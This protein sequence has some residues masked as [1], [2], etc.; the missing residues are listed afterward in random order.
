MNP[1]RRGLVL[2]G[3]VAAAANA[4]SAQAPVRA[5][6]VTVR[7]APQTVGIGEAI[8]LEVRVRTAPGV[9]VRFPPVPDSA[10]SIEPL[11]PR[12]ITDRSTAEQLDRTAT[13]RFIAWDLGAR[14]LRLGDVTLLVEGSARRYPV[15]VPP[16][17]VRS[18]L[19]ADS[20]RRT[21]REAKPMAALPWDGWRWVIALVVV[22]GLA[23][24]G[25]H[26]WRRKHPRVAAQD[27]TPDAFPIAEAAF[28]HAGALGLLEAG[29]S[30]RFA[31]IHVQV[32]RDYLARRFPKA[33]RAA[34]R[35]ELTELLE[36][37]DLPILPL[38]VT[39][40]LERAEPIA[41]AR[42][43]LAPD[44]ARLIAEEAK[45]IVTDVETAWQLR[46]AAAERTTGRTN[47]RGRR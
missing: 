6:L 2:I 10:E 19:P 7:V 28:T 43:A 20:A 46:R 3:M 35:R 15:V 26:S 27:E 34:S 24:W 36:T 44:E 21:P 47:G 11:D 4:V 25:W 41:F 38:R 22:L 33:H 13:Y 29:E 31:I 16:L 14:P 8:T 45:R 39:T 32:M 1:M 9:E 42:A 12:A 40:L 37:I 5:P 18:V 17:R 30:G 23:G